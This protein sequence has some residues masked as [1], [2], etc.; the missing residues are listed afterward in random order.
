MLAVKAELEAS[1]ATFDKAWVV[2]AADNVPPGEQPHATIA[3]GFEDTDEM[4]GW[5]VFQVAAVGRSHGIELELTNVTRTGTDQ[6]GTGWMKA[7]PQ[8]GRDNAE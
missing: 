8:E 3:A 7:S 1:G 6:Q 5:M 4:L 2:I